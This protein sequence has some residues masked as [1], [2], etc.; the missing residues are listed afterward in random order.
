MLA[1]TCYLVLLL[2]L[3]GTSISMG[4]FIPLLYIGACFGNAIG[5]WMQVGQS[6]VVVY[7]I[8]CS[9]AMLAGVARV[10][11][12]LTTIMVCAT[13]LTYMVAPFMLVTVFAKVTGKAMFGRPG[14]YDVILEMKGIPFLESD[15]P[16]SMR[17]RG[18]KAEDIMSSSPLITL[19]PEQNIGE[20]IEYLKR[21]PHFADFPVVDPSRDGI[22][23]GVVTRDDL[24]TILTHRELFYEPGDHSNND[25][26]EE[27][28]E[29]IQEQPKADDHTDQSGRSQLLEKKPP[30][31]ALKFEELVHDRYHK[32]LN[33]DTVMKTVTEYDFSKVIDLTPY[34]E[35]G[36]YTIH[37]KVSVERT[38]EQFRTLGLRDLVVTDANGRPVGVITRYDLKLLEEVG[39][40]DSR[41]SRKRENVGVYANS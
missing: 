35:I 37:Q 39:M 17:M 40:D 14:I 15:P 19:T 27:I 32:A 38:F 11:I 12:S 3:F 13:G 36:H 31:R 18:M 5:T 30:R 8:A 29:A 23:L 9:V 2:L 33:I 20:L 6:V 7:S 4:I 10:L 22:Y 24:Y 41:V 28:K 16:S 1:G 34:M 25:L 26:E 21:H